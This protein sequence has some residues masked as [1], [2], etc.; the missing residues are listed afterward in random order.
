LFKYFTAEKKLVIKVVG[1]LTEEAMF[2]VKE[3][4]KR[5]FDLE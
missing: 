3:E 2:K 5:I 4:L 1:R